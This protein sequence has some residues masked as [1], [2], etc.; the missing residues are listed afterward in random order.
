V[1]GRLAY[2]LL[3]LVFRSYEQTVIFSCRNSSDRLNEKETNETEVNKCNTN[4]S[5]FA[6]YVHGG[7]HSGMKIKKAIPL[8][9]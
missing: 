4:S 1:S 9:A 3:A 7:W 5:A 6:A 8:Q 2:K